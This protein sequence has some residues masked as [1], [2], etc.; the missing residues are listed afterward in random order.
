[1]AYEKKAG[2][3]SLFKNNYK[4]NE[5]KPDY[6]GSGLD[7]NGNPIKVAA[8]VR[9]TRNGEQF[10]SLKI[11]RDEQSAPAPAPQQ[12]GNRKPLYE[13]AAEMS[14]TPDLPF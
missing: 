14:E 13:M 7:I 9:Q 10:F 8:W 11:E 4:D 12:Q 6:K 5:R 3:V 1:M 2:E